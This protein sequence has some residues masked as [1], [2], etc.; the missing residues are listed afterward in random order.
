MGRNRFVKPSVVRLP[1]SDEDWI[2]VKRELTSGEQRHIFSQIVKEHRG[3]EKPILDTQKVGATRLIEY[4]VGWSLC[5]ENG[6]VALTPSAI[7]NLDGETFLE[8]VS[9]I[10][11]HEL[12][13][14]AERAE[15]KNAKAGASASSPLSPS[16]GS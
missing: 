16:A 2:D 1:L 11:A 8:I 15:R 14:E 3:G 6:P 7:D 9:A 12:K 10:D 13:I 5:D 4:L